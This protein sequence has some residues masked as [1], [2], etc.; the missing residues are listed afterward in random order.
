MGA[1]KMTGSARHRMADTIQAFG[2][3]FAMGT[4]TSTM[5]AAV[6]G[7]LTPWLCATVGFACGVGFAVWEAWNEFRDSRHA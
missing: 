6:L 4:A 3:G 5:V 7:V 1:E 2:V